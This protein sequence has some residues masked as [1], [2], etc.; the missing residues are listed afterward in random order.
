MTLRRLLHFASNLAILV[1]LAPA[2]SAVPEAE[3]FIRDRQQ[4]LAE[5]IQKKADDRIEK[6]FDSMLDYP[7]LAKESLRDH[8]AE[9]TPEERAKFQCVLRQLVARAY[10]QNLSKTLGYR[11]RFE[12]TTPATDGFVVTTVAQN[13]KNVR[14]API[15]IAYLVH[16]Q[17][18]NWRIYDIVTEGS[19]LVRNYRNQFGR[20]LKKQGFSELLRRMQKKLG[21]AASQC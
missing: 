14:E 10:R 19:S 12:Q 7:S 3:S 5:F 16:R 13:T 6:T 15:T 1:A 11:I 2:A 4:D 20:V 18:G 17:K 21:P 9:R 8:W